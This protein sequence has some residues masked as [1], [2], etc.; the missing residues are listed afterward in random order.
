MKRGVRGLV[1]AAAASFIC[2]GSAVAGFTSLGTPAGAELNHEQILEGIYGGDFV[3]MGV[4]LGTGWSI[5][6]NGT[7]TATRVDDD[8][9]V[10]YLHMLYGGPGTGDDDEWTDGSASAQAE[11]RYAGDN[12]EFGY[13]KGAGYVKLFDLVG[14]G[15]AVTGSAMITF[16]PGDVW[17]WARATDSDAGLTNPHYSLPSMNP[18]A[19]DHMVTYEITG[20]PFALPTDKVWLLCFEDRNLPGSDRDHNDLCVELVVKDC[21]S[22][23]ECDDG[24]ECTIDT[25]NVAG[26]CD[27][28]FA[29]AGSACGN[30]TPEGVCDNPDVCDGAGMCVPNYEPDTTVC[31]ASLGD[32]DPA[33]YCTGSSADCPA[34]E[35]APFGTVC[36]V[37]AGPCDIEELCD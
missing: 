5:Y 6:D 35:I 13:D 23:S 24:N 14:S 32:C 36:R 1:V 7:T 37:V 3:G 31:N 18:D 26:Q 30:Q 10:T 25:C 20:S 11:A 2:A 33:E 29:S 22:D 16:N 4:A 9:Y 27:Y 12:Q 21:F 17:V 8:G 28:T 19:V 34:D 15:F